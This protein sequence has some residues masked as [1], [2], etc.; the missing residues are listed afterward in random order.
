MGISNI[1]QILSTRNTDRID[2]DYILSRFPWLMKRGQKCILSPDSDGLLCGLFMSHYLDWDIV[3]YYDG[4]VLLLRD[5]LSTYDEDVVFLDIEVYRKHVKSVGHHM[6]L[7]NKRVI[8]NTWYNFDNCLQPNILREL[9]GK[10]YFRMKYPLATIH[11]L[12]SIIGTRINIPVNERTIAPLF[13]VDGTFNVLYSY[14]ENVMNWLDYLRVDSS[15]NPLREVFM[16]DHYT[17]YG[18]MKVMRDFFRRRD[19]LSVDRQRGD[20]FVISTKSGDFSENVIHQ[21]GDLYRIEDDAKRRLLSFLSIL[22]EHTGWLL[23]EGKWTLG[24][25]KRFKFSKG[26]F[27][28]KGWTLTNKNFQSFMEQNPLSWAMTSGNNIEFTLETPDVLP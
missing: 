1:E 18:Q 16:H 10:N 17:V 9:D 6:L 23:D 22:S 15:N 27:Q 13:F 20:K 24:D 3:G 5:G 2:I 7:F 11:L 19:E 21:L 14:P 26:N 4:K 8:P 25:L 28:E 12:L